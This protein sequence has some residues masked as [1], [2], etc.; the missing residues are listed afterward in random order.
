M[1]IMRGRGQIRPLCLSVFVVK[2]F[3]EP[4]VLV[5][6]FLCEL[7][8]FVV[9]FQVSPANSVVPPLDQTSRETWGSEIWDTD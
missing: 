5:V 3:R 2:F 4:C 8:A 6:K 9:K 7:C 1:K